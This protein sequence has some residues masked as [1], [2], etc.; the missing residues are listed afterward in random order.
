MTVELA[1]VVAKQV[2]VYELVSVFTVGVL[3]CELDDELVAPLHRHRFDG[4]R[5]TLGVILEERQGGVRTP[6]GVDLLHLH[7]PDQAISDGSAEIDCMLEQADD[8]VRHRD[9]VVV[10]I[11]RCP[12]LPAD[13]AT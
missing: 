1:I 8:A 3:V 6:V 4:E 2:V 10:P 9:W 13:V 11:L 12:V 7:V 5:A